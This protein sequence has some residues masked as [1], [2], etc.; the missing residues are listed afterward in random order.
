MGPSIGQTCLLAPFH[1]SVASQVG[2]YT[3]TQIVWGA[4][5]GSLGT[6]RA[7]D[8]HSTAYLCFLATLKLRECATEPASTVDDRGDL[9]KG[10]DAYL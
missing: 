4:L 3:L 9:G 7:I 5:L 1:V 8:D 6:F 10:I 2:V